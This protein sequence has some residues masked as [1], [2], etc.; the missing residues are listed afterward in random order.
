MAGPTKPKP[1]GKGV[2]PTLE[3]TSVSVE[4]TSKPGREVKGGAPMNFNVDPEFRREFKTFAA[5]RDM[6]QKEL[7]E[8]AFYDYVKNHG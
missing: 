2:A 4:T 6:S 1:K 5:S 7:L 8:K 3:Q